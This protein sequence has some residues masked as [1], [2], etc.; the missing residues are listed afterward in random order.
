MEGAVSSSSQHES[1]STDEYLERIYLRFAMIESDEQLQK[2]T[3]A[4]LI[5]LI[6]TAGAEPKA[7]TK[8]GEIL[9]HYNRRAKSNPAVK[10]PV[11]TLLSMLN[12]KSAVTANLS[13]VY[14]RFAT[15]HLND[16]DYLSLL[17]VLLEVLSSKI[18]EPSQCADDEIKST[19]E[20]IRSG[21]KVSTPAMTVDE[22]LMVAEKVFPKDVSIVP[23][24]LCVVKLLTSGLFED[25]AIFSI[26][27]LGSAEGIE[28]V[29]G[30][31]EAILKKIDIQL[32]VDNRVVVDEL[33]AAYLGTTMP[34]KPVIG[35]SSAVSPANSMMKQKIL[36]FLTRS[37]I[38]PVSYMNNMKVCLDGL[39][40]TSITKLLI[41]ALNF[42]LKVIEKMP[43][44]AQKNLSLLLFQRLQKILG[45]V[46]NGTAVSLIYRCMGMLG[47][48]DISIVSAQ[49]ET[50]M[51]AFRAIATVSLLSSAHSS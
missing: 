10:Y 35:K 17:P 34:S 13:L 43:A 18:N 46:K 6:E 12:G 31:A 1:V 25:S 33:M 4:Y 24:K 23:I 26:I 3:D 16:D 15:V 9:S 45:E 41:A 32:C 21:T 37:A 42:L 29:S 7:V 49:E 47:N 39:T 50:V 2:F 5:R 36:Q 8:V 22:Y 48:R 14:L 51:L 20:A 19:C 44:A 38:A 40:Q 27:V 11:E 28:A 30:A